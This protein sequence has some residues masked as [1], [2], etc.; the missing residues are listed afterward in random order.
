[1]GVRR[2]MPVNCANKDCLGLRKRVCGLHQTWKWLHQTPA[3]HE[4]LISASSV[5]ANTSRA[6]KNATV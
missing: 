6:T 4:Y 3:L 2:S 1:M 5:A